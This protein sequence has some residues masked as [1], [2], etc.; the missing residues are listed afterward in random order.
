[1]LVIG[2]TERGEQVRVTPAP[3]CFLCGGDGN[4]LYRGLGD[5]RGR[6][7]GVWDWRHC[8]PCGLLWLDP[9][10]AREHIGRL[11]ADYY[12]HEQG[13]ASGLWP[14]LRENMRLALLSGIDGYEGLA[15]DRW[16]HR[17][18]RMALRVPPLREMARLG[19]MGLDG[20]S[21]GYLLDVGCGSGRFL[22]LM[23]RAGW[24][25]AAVEPDPR[26]AAVAADRYGIAV[27]AGGLGEAALPERVFDAVVL[28][29]VVEHVA[30]PLS[31][32]AGCR[33]VLRPGGRLALSTPNVESR[34]HHL[35][36]PRWLHLDV[37]RHL[38]LFSKSCLAGLLERAGFEQLAIT[39]AAKSAASTWLS[40]VAAKQGRSSGPWACAAALGF[41]LAEWQAVSRGD[42]C[43]EELFAWAVRC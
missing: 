2:T 13:T 19:L 10:P 31:L 37:P 11:Y 27:C 17:L 26:A 4:I 41:H 25:V 22:S 3:T 42:D 1:M 32:L 28:S 33:R 5:V 23:R 18:A 24:Q 14:R 34:G 8:G 16:Q 35:F 39:T 12:T 15:P 43:G 38:H 29:H 30:D 9:C 7:P 21:K 36:G 6:V 40:S 20:A